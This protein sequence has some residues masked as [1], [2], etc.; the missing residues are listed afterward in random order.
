MSRLISFEF[1]TPLPFTVTLNAGELE[2][3]EAVRVLPGRR[4]VCRARWRG[5]EVFAKLF[6]PNTR[7]RADWQREHGNYHQLREAGVIM[8]ELLHAQQQARP[9]CAVLLYKSLAPASTAKQLWERADEPGREALLSRLVETVAAHHAAGVVQDDPHLENFIISEDALYSLDAGGFAIV[10]GSPGVRRALD[11]LGLLFA[12]LPVEYDAYAE[13][14]LARYRC[15][16]RGIHPADCGTPPVAE[17]AELGAAIR[18]QRQRRLQ[19]FGKKVMRECSAFIERRSWRHK[20]LVARRHASAG[21]WRYLDE[22]ERAF[23]RDEHYL[24]RGN[25]STVTGLELENTRLVFKR[26]NLKNFWHRLRRCWRPTRAAHSWM[27][28]NLLVFLEIPTAE[29]VAMLE[30]RFGPLRGRGYFC[31]RHVAGIDLLEYMNS[32]LIAEA[33][34]QRMSVSVAGLFRRL[35]SNKIAHGDMKATNIIIENGAP[36]LID[37]DAMQLHTKPATFNTAFQRDLERFFHN[38][39]ASPELHGM[40]ARAFAAADFPAGLRIP[41]L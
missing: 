21:L 32:P 28:A 26:Y 16:G 5:N 18:A 13:T 22:P 34:K 41:E 8:P 27:N 15:A 17:V 25:S 2:C 6:A 12:Q 35:A 24:K 38:W 37:L 20:L 4:M 11:N 40:F 9:A 7:A 14:M 1:H 23:A 33:D 30:N 19:K 31:M 3:L 29:P 36:V 39:H 10:G